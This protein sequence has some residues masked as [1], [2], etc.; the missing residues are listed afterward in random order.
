MGLIS[1]TR[2]H[3]CSHRPSPRSQ[4]PKCIDFL[5]H[6]LILARRNQLVCLESAEL[7]QD[8]GLP[9]QQAAHF[10]LHRRHNFPADLFC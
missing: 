9:S 5:L 4:S 2:A 1:H 7:H 10:R 3:P 8:D 6:S